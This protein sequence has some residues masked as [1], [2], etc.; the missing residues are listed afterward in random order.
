MNPFGSVYTMFE[1]P[2]GGGGGNVTVIV[3]GPV[4]A[5]T[6]MVMLLVTCVCVMCALL[7]PEIEPTVTL[8]TGAACGGGFTDGSRLIVRLKVVPRGALVG[9]TLRMPLLVPPPPPPPPPVVPVIGSKVA[10]AVRVTR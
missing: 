10:T 5:P 1:P 2:P 8:P 6:G 9:V 7:V 3:C 4:L